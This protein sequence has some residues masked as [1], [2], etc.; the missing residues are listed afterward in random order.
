MADFPHFP[1][2]AGLGTY[3]QAAQIG[4]TV[5]QDVERFVR[6]AWLEKQAMEMGMAWLNPTPEWEVKEALS[7]HLYLD[8]D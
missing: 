7:L 8:A 3:E 4:Y 2:L 6:Y 5:E 1:P